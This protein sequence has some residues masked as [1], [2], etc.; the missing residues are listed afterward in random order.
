MKTIWKCILTIFWGLIMG[1]FFKEEP[2]ATA[3]IVSTMIV[4]D[5]LVWIRGGN[6][7]AFG[8][9][10]KIEKLQRKIQKLE[11]KKKLKQLQTINS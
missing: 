5:Y 2:L 10:T 7:Y 6:S 11:L 3:I 4:L 8:D 9:V 1:F